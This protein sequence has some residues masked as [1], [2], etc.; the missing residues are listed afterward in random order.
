MRSPFSAALHRA[1]PWRYSVVMSPRR[2]PISA[3]AFNISRTVYLSP[4]MD[5]ELMRYAEEN[6]LDVTKS[7]RQLIERGLLAPK[8][9]AFVADRLREVADAKDRTLDD[10]V[11]EVLTTFALKNARTAK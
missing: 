2:D 3:K 4:Q 9:P 8:L 5:R 7:I 6:N 10:L 1:L 11:L